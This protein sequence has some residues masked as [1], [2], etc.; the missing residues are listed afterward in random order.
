MGYRSFRK[1]ETVTKTDR[2]YIDMAA[3]LAAQ[4]VV[5]DLACNNHNSRIGE[6]E[7][8]VFNGVK[9]RG[10]HNERNIRTNRKFLFYGIG[11][12]FLGVVAAFIRNS[13][14]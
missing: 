11:F 2:E 12:L 8:V 13:F 5:K 14:V 1:G 6:V 4:K 3:T 7:K 10:E 9:E